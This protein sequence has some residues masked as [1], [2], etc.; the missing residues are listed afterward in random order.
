MNKKN[1]LYAARAGRPFRAFR[2]PA[3]LTVFLA[4]G[5]LV[6]AAAFLGNGAVFYEPLINAY[7]PPMA[8]VP[9]AMSEAADAAVA[10][11]MGRSTMPP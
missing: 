2:W 7:V 11:N 9:H 10:K 6:A 5:S 8:T 3:G 1:D 4:I